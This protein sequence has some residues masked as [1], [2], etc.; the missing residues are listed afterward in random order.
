MG[1]LGG[2][3]EPD[4][5]LAVVA[6]DINDRIS[7]VVDMVRELRDEA[8]LMRSIALRLLGE[9][10]QHRSPCEIETLLFESSFTDTPAQ[11]RSRSDLCRQTVDYQEA[12]GSL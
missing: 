12:F 4:W 8:E 6:N 5:Q 2:N 7:P 9:L 1:E 11:R 3:S 10:G